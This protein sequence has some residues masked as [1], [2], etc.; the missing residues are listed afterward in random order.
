MKSV[1]YEMRWWEG[2]G[3]TCL[4]DIRILEAAVCGDEGPV[5]VRL[6][7]TVLEDEV[8]ELHVSLRRGGGRSG[9]DAASG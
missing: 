2:G 9:H 1:R 6:G 3:G 8:E 5:D 4:G 7:F